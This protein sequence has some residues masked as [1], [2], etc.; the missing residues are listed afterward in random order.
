MFQHVR[1]SRRKHAQIVRDSLASFLAHGSLPC[2]NRLPANRHLV[3]TGSSI[4]LTD[5]RTRI[6]QIIEL[7]HS[8]IGTTL[9]VNLCSQSFCVLTCMCIHLRPRSND[10]SEQSSKMASEADGT[11]FACASAAIAAGRLWLRTCPWYSSAVPRS[12]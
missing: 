3:L 11:A 9:F 4:M 6:L 5:R 1:T 10:E 2:P 7:Q 8:P 12:R